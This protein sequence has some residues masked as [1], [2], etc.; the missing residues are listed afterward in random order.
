MFQSKDSVRLD[1]TTRTYSMLPIGE[2][3][4]AKDTYKLEMRQKKHFILREMTRK[5]SWQ[6]SYQTKQT[7]KQ[8]QSHKKRQKS[9]LYN[10]KGINPVRGCYTN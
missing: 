5:W 10:D 2:H 4:R 6:Q 7:L 8:K 9:A 3:F 1:N